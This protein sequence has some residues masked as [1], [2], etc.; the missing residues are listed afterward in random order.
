MFNKKVIIKIF[1]IIIIFLFFST[2]ALA[3]TDEQKEL[4]IL[5]EKLLLRV[6]SLENIFFFF[7]NCINIDFGR[8]LKQEMSGRDIKCMQILINAA[9]KT[10]KEF[11]YF[12]E[13]TKQAVVNFQELYKKEILSP[14]FLKQG[15][16]Y[17]GI[18]TRAKLNTLLKELMMEKIIRLKNIIQEIE[19]LNEQLS[20]LEY[21]GGKLDSN[22]NDNDPSTSPLDRLGTGSG[23]ANGGDTVEEAPVSGGGSAAPA[24]TPEAEPTACQGQYISGKHIY[25]VS[26]KNIPRISQI[27]INPLDVAYNAF[28]EV[29]VSI[30]DANNNPVNSATGIAITDSKSTSFNLILI[31]GTEKDGIWKGSWK[32]EDSICNKYV[33]TIEAASASGNSKVDLTFK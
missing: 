33:I 16:G 5:L 13:A 26:T 12:D 9:S 19:I 17:V 21:F 10:E 3:K 15:T 2:P 14:L 18:R 8:D 11:G 6:Q 25:A 30:N 29:I 32:L 4:E 28:Q 7:S 23:Q 24:P 1:I 22:N 20:E 27:E 31:S